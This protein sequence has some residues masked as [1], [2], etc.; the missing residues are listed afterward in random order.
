MDQIA[1]LWNY[2]MDILVR[3]PNKIN[4]IIEK[5]NKIYENQKDGQGYTTLVDMLEDLDLYDIAKISGE[6]H[7]LDIPQQ[8]RDG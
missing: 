3:I 4:P 6:E 8:T 5:L 2:G 7:F 1:F